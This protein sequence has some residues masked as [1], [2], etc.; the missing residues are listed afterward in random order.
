MK[1]GNVNDAKNLIRQFGRQT[2]EK[3]LEIA[4]KLGVMIDQKRLEKSLFI[5]HT[6][7]CL[8]AEDAGDVAEMSSAVAAAVEGVSEEN[9]SIA[10]CVNTCGI[11]FVQLATGQHE[12]ALEAF[13][14]VRSVQGY[15]LRNDYK[16]MFSINGKKGGKARHEPMNRV[17]DEMIKIFHKGG[18]WKSIRQAS[19]KL[20]DKAKEIALSE[21]TKFTTDDVPA[22][23]YSWFLKAKKM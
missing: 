8:I 6:M 14:L 3:T 19:I 2:H 4:E 15:L 12:R 16:K 5:H 10:F 1:E 9:L 18:N 23:L 22:R 17:K 11:G 21:G 20:E 13:G 7:V